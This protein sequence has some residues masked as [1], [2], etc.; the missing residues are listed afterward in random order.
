[1]SEATVRIDSVAAGGDGVAR[2][3]GLVVFVPR[4]APGDVGRVRYST[5]GRFARGELVQL[6]QPSPDR[7]EPPCAHYVVDR[8]GGCQIQHLRYEAQLAVK[9]RIVRDALERIGRRPMELAGTEAS[10]REWRYRRKLTMGL[11]RANDAP[12]WSAGL[13]PYDAP[14][15]IFALRDCP[16]TEQRVLDIWAGVMR[17]SE[18]FPRARSLRGAVRVAPDGGAWSSFVLEGGRDWTASARFFERVTQLVELWWVPEGG[19]RRLLHQRGDAGAPGAA[20]TQVNSE[21]AAMLRAHVLDE[22]G[23]RPHASVIDAYSGVGDTAIALARSGA[24]VTA[25]ELDPAAAAWC[26]EL[27]PPGSRAVAARV[28]DALPTFLPA[29]LVVLNPPRAGVDARV[30]AALE[31]QPP[32]TLIYVSCNP[33]TLARDL[34]RLPGFSVRSLRAFDMFPQTAHVETVCVLHAREAA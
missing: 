16:I 18:F 31:A 33:A 5:R 9:A 3:E 7:I 24:S 10:P 15:R 12:R 6:E 27:L 17:A 28:E 21:M 23:R 8:C 1:M 4:T 29:D 26:A 30:S 32:R 20:F 2:L 22:A 34:S 13:H 14:G 19:E 25:I 11:R